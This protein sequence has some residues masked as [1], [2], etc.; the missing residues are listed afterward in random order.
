MTEYY[1]TV[2]TLVEN[3]NL[4]DKGTQKAGPWEMARLLLING[5]PAPWGKGSGKRRKIRTGSARSWGERAQS[6]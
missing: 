1:V 4:P 2:C 3:G 5:E 6:S